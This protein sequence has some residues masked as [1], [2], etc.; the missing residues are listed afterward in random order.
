MEAIGHRTLTLSPVQPV[1]FSFDQCRT[2][3]VER[4]RKNI[5][6]VASRWH[7]GRVLEVNLDHCSFAEAAISSLA[8]L[9]PRWAWL[10]CGLIDSSRWRSVG[11]A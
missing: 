6:G 2:G 8:R 4:A 10:G 1:A 5:P 3:V 7:Q 9:G 11:M